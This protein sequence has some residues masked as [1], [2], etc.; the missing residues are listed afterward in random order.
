MKTIVTRRFEIDAGHRINGHKGKCCFLHG[1]RYVFEVSVSSE[2]LD[3]LGMV[4]DFSVIKE[5]IGAWLDEEW[6]HALILSGDDPLL[7]AVLQDPDSNLFVFAPGVQPTIENLVGYLMT[8]AK[9]RLEG[10]GLCV[11]SVKGWETPN[12]WA[13]AYP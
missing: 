10:L 5:K 1:H 13:V 2:D 9:A 4:V 3:K 12:C 7:A 8:V 6:D 11:E